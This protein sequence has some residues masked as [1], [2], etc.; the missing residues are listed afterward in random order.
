M[1]HKIARAGASRTNVCRNLHRLLRGA[2]VQYPVEI[3]TV[4]VTIRLRKPE[5]H[6]E[7]LQWPI[8]RLSDW[9]R[10]LLKCHPSYLL[11]GMEL[12]DTLGWQH[13]FATFWETYRTIDPDH[14]VFSAGLELANVVPYA[15]HGDEGKGLRGKP[16]LVESFQPVIGRHGM[17]V[18]N[19]SGKLAEQMLAFKLL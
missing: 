14:E 7:V 3:A 19:E 1:L 9:V 12:E 4:P 11:G 5:P 2:G 10:A 15:L 6:N 18:T 17:F 8:I 16:F 13:Q